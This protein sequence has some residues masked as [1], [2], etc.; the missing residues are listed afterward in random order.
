M[1]WEESS[2]FLSEQMKNLLEKLLQLTPKNRLSAREILKHPVINEYFGER[3]TIE[4]TIQKIKET[5]PPV[6]PQLDDPEDL[7]YF[8]TP[9]DI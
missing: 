1:N 6:T 8:E 2:E 4:E 7:L 3:S 5:E 9:S